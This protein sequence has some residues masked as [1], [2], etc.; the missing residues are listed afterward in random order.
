MK[1]RNSEDVNGSEVGFVKLILIG[2]AAGFAA[3]AIKTVCE[4]I[5]PP[6]APGVP[7]PLG[8]A[9]NAVA[10]GLTGHPLP[11]ETL[12]VAEPVVHFIFGMG[13]GAVYALLVKKIPLT[14]LAYGTVFGIGFWV[15]A[16]E[17]V[18]PLMGLSSTAAQMT[19]WEQGNEFVSHILFGVA[20]EFT[21]RFGVR[22]LA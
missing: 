10:M 21:R 17:I 16:H 7:S 8:N 18:L 20:L 3:T 11:E 14:R 22:K 1:S 2:L 6:R 13:A 5:S 15:V 12:K 4:L 9:I 19:L